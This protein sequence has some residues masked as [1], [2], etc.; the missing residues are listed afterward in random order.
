MK[1]D[2]PEALTFPLADALDV[3]GSRE[4]LGAALSMDGVP[5]VIVWLG[6]EAGRGP[7]YVLCAFREELKGGVTEAAGVLL[8]SLSGIAVDGQPLLAIKDKY[9]GTPLSLVA[10][11]HKQGK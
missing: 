10:T 4:A 2:E 11:E 3:K 8:V 5:R 1:D 6:K 7:A 9:L